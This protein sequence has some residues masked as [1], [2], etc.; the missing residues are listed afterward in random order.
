MGTCSIR[1]LALPALVHPYAS[2]S[3]VE[4]PIETA[5]H[6][7]RSGNLLFR[8]FQPI[9]TALAFSPWPEAGPFSSERAASR[10]ISVW[11]RMASPSRLSSALQQP[12]L[13]DRR[14]R[15]G[16]I[17]RGYEGPRPCCSPD[18]SR[19]RVEEERASP[20]THLRRYG[21]VGVERDARNRRIGSLG[22]N[23]GDDLVRPKMRRSRR[24]RCCAVV[25]RVVPLEDLPPNPFPPGPSE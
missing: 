23:G 3:R 1:R 14:A 9:S 17:E 21:R 7:P 11:S 8:L 6:A 12:E 16:L 22:A 15:V 13:A 2:Y 19:V 18:L 5:S 25:V 10:Y 24:G 20:D 4:H